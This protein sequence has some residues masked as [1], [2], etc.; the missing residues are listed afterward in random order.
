[1]N[2]T[3]L[4]GFYN[5]LTCLVIFA[6]AC[7]VVV[8]SLYLYNFHG[9]FGNQDMFAKFGDFLG[10]VL[11]P[12]FS[13]LT[14]ILLVSSLVMQRQELSKVVEELEM[15]RNVH[16]SSVNMRHYEH[17]IKKFEE[18]RSDLEDAAKSFKYALE[19]EIKLDVFLK[20]TPEKRD[21]SIFSIFADDRLFTHAN[22]NGYIT[23]IPSSLLSRKPEFRTFN[24]KTELL[25]VHIKIMASEIKQIR[26]L[27]CPKL[28]AKEMIEVGTDLI[29]YDHLS[30]HMN[31][32]FRI[33]IN[34]ALPSFDEFKDIFM[35]YPE[36]PKVV[37]NSN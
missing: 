2:A 20:E 6:V 31:E 8:I 18:G 21:Y 35:N 14:V 29:N 17:I 36:N 11:N 34:K 5:G 19:E 16:Q 25:N 24:D 13:F 9:D 30:L 1:M 3:N 37:F 12:I 26:D 33:N 32:S 7:M 27:G 4:K 28:R 22:K 10:G 15:T 23:N